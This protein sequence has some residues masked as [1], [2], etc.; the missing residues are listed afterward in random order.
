MPPKLLKQEVLYKMTDNGFISVGNVS[1]DGITLMANAKDVTDKYSV[2]YASFCGHSGEMELHFKMKFIDRLKWVW[3]FYLRHKYVQICA[4]IRT[5]C[6][7]IF[8]KKA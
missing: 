7:K 6:A 4:K 5:F 1:P 8:S 3:R 2:P